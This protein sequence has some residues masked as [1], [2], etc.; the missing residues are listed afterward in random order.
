MSSDADKDPFVNLATSQAG[1]VMEELIAAARAGQVVYL[2]GPGDGPAAAA[3]VPIAVAE[4]G[5][6][7]LAAQA[8][9]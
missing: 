1:M 2:T 3:V 9:P 6:A 8:K 7:A 4:A 5:L